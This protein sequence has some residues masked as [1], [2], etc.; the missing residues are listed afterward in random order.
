MGPGY[1][2][3][4]LPKTSPSFLLEVGGGS[5]AVDLTA[6]QRK[7]AVNYTVCGYDRAGYGKSWQ[8]SKQGYNITMDIMQKTMKAVGFP[9]DVDRNVI[10]VGHSAGG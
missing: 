3:T 9:I 4:S 8:G 7:L 5:S 6:V 1:T 10:C 2:N